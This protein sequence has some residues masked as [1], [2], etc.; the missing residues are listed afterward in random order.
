M[1]AISWSSLLVLGVFAVMADASGAAGEPLLDPDSAELD[2]EAIADLG[3]SFELSE[4]Q[5][6]SRSS[7][8]R[9]G[10]NSSARGTPI[11]R[12]QPAPPSASLNGAGERVGG[13]DAAGDD[14]HSFPKL[15]RIPMGGMEP[16]TG[17][18]KDALMMQ[19]LP[20][21][22]PAP[23][24]DR[25]NAM[26]MGGSDSLVAIALGTAEGTRIPDGGK[27]FAYYGHTDPTT[28][29]WTV[30]TFSLQQG[31][32]SPEDADK[33]HLTKLQDHARHLQQQAR[34]QAVPWTMETQLHGLDVVNQFPQAALS[35]NNGFVALLRLTY[36][37]G[38]D[39]SEA[40]EW[41]R[42]RMVLTVGT[43]T[44]GTDTVGTER[45]GGAGSIMAQRAAAEQVRRHHAIAHVLANWRSPSTAPSS[46]FREGGA[47]PNQYSD[48]DTDANEPLRW[49]FPPESAEDR[50]DRLLSLDLEA[51]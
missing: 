44:V 12:M 35:N 23:E 49:E 11:Q 39:A 8:S 33:A 4:V 16:P 51:V 18:A 13:G 2:R 31:S 50:I 19:E 6:Q 42:T 34:E 27:T 24:F 30:G 20:P 47:A 41:A 29:I 48:G 22:P 37:R 5:P 32:E 28:D 9:F 7:A 46:S 21:P 38:M 36:E 45:E 3:L 40:I 26:F 17:M 1:V 25:L 14:N 15:L 43:D 10:A